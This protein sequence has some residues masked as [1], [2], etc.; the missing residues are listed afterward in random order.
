MDLRL[1]RNDTQDGQVVHISYRDT[2]FLQR[3][4]IVAATTRTAGAAAATVTAALM[5]AA[6]IT[7]ASRQEEA[8]IARP[9]T[10]REHTARLTNSTL[11]MEEK[12]LLPLVVN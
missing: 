2:L 3:A 12:A 5:P 6:V 11:F 7:A 1:E 4:T 8:T 9:L 10:T